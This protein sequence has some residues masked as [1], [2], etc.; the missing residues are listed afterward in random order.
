MDGG[1]Q[2]RDDAA[3]ERAG[4]QPRRGV[5]G[6]QPL[7]HRAVHEHPG[8][9]GDEQDPLC[10]VP[11]RESGGGLVGVDVQR[12]RGERCDHRD[13]TSGE[14]RANLGG[15]GRL[16]VADQAERLHPARAQP[17]RVAPQR[18]RVRADRRADLRVDLGQRLADDLEHLGG[19]HAASVDEG[20]GEPATLDLGR[21]LRT[22]A[23]H[24]DHLVPLL[25][26]LGRAARSV[27]G[28]PAAQLQHD[29]AH[30]VYSALMRT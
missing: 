26:Q 3:L 1:G 9:V 15:S 16:G 29:H 11:D 20:R 4:D 2:L 13:A 8:H 25:P 5:V 14:R 10:A 12:A 7:D 22:G 21:D 18:Q 23:V 28:D 27:G 17:D 6:V 24:H 19:G 30:V